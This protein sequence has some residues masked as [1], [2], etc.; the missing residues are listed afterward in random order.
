MQF[1]YRVVEQRLQ[2]TLRIDEHGGLFLSVMRDQ[3]PEGRIS[4]QNRDPALRVPGLLTDLYMLSPS[5]D[6]L[7]KR[8]VGVTDFLQPR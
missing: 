7:C 8:V 5:C 3:L 1:R 4:Q 2:P 6:G